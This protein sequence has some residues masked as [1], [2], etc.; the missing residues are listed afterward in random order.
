MFLEASYTITLTVSQLA[1]LG[2]DQSV[3]SEWEQFYSEVDPNDFADGFDVNDPNTWKQ[4]GFDLNN[5]DTWY[6]VLG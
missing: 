5:P 1:E 2:V 4:F 3:I 6:N